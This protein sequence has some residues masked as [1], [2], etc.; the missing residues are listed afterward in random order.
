VPSLFRR[1]NW[2][3]RFLASKELALTLFLFL[4][5]SLVP[6]TFTKTTEIHLSVWHGILFGLMGLNLVLCTV[7]RIKALSVPV[8]VMHLGALLI[9]L[10][11]AISSSGYV[12]T[13]NIYEGSMVDTVYRWDVKKDLPLGVDLTVK[14]IHV[15]YYPVSVRVGVLRGEEKVGLF[16]LKTGES[17]TLDR[18]TVRPD[19]LE[20]PS[21]ELKLT[22]FQG[23]NNIGSTDTGGVHKLSSDFPYDF[24][25]VAYKTPS[26][27][28]V[29]VDLRL[30]KGTQVLTEG[31]TEINR[32][33]TWGKLNFYN[34]AIE[35]DNYGMPFAGIQI[36]NDPGKPY[37]YVG[38]LVIGIGSLMY[39]LR[40]LYGYK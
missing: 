35:V 9:L 1:F 4:C 29:V 11:A 13:A 40:R 36:T 7:R 20:F 5:V 30:S 14:K 22:I 25:L 6:R 12:A 3:Y 39:F 19:S 37:V 33:L 32:P 16:E 17:F 28:R 2:L 18:Y 21:G 26:Y 8:I 24:R 27:K 10:G 34:T 23:G 15:D 38:F 31:T